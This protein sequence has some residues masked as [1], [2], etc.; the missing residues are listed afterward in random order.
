[1][2]RHATYHVGSRRDTFL[3]AGQGPSGQ[4][5]RPHHVEPERT[6]DGFSVKAPRLE[7]HDPGRGDETHSCNSQ[8]R[9]SATDMSLRL[10]CTASIPLRHLCPPP[11]FGYE[12]MSSPDIWPRRCWL[13]HEG[14]HH[15]LVCHRLFHAWVCMLRERTKV[16][17]SR[18]A[19]FRRCIAL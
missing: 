2:H 1:M 13:L 5:F 17:S 12:L 15:T 9:Y 14:G 3:G 11:E 7:R 16:P 19:L 18:V 6:A 4:G 10:S 8:L